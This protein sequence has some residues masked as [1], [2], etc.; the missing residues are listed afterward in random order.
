[1]EAIHCMTLNA[2]KS[3]GSL[4]RLS[5]YLEEV[6]QAMPAIN[7]IYIS[8]LEVRQSMHE[9]F[10]YPTSID[11]WSL[12]R[13]WPG[14]G[15]W[16]MLVMVHSSLLPFR[17]KSQERGRAMSV[18]FSAR[19]RQSQF[20][21]FAH[22]DPA[23]VETTYSDIAYLAKKRPRRSNLIV[24][25]DL[26]ADQLPTYSLDSFASQSMRHLHHFHQRM[27]LSALFDSLG[28]AI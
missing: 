25:G 23:D 19:A 3:L 2:G 14:P 5:T 26:N 21:V 27:A 8:E 7:L 4:E 11:A 6:T 18:T 20:F 16:A 9:D 22:A 12:H 24:A 10:S 13:H 1:M 17:K 28:I 15:S